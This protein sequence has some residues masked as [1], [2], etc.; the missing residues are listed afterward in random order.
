MCWNKSAPCARLRRQQSGNLVR[1]DHGTMLWNTGV[2]SHLAAMLVV[3]ATSAR[4][5]VVRADVPQAPL[6]TARTFE[7]PSSRTV[8]AIVV[9]TLLVFVGS[10][11]VWLRWRQ[12]AAHPRPMRKTSVSAFAPTSRGRVC[13]ACGRTLPS[14]AAHCSL[15][16]APGVERDL[17]EAERPP[18]GCP[19]CGVSYPADLRICPNDG[20]ALMATPMHASM[21]SA[22]HGEGVERVCP[23]CGH[24]SRHEKFCSADGSLLEALN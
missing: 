24:R 2:R 17:V 21:V 20:D 13:S 10:L 16:G 6:V 22:S 1:F 3:V 5:A 8:F 18:L 9:G 4:T 23:A 11:G 15:D 19:T 12:R 7:S 14:G